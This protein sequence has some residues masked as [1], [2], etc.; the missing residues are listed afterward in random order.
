MDDEFTTISTKLLDYELNGI[1][2]QQKHIL[3]N[4][5]ERLLRDATAKRD[6]LAVVKIQRLQ[7]R[8]STLAPTQLETLERKSIVKRNSKIL[9]VGIFV[10][11]LAL[12]LVTNVATNIL[13]QAITPYLWLSWPLLIILS[14]ISVF[15]IWRQ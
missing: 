9:P 11:G 12:T 6:A 7:T 5:M 2:E 3:M 8:L 13:P 14:L 15:L 1:T 4:A 10:V